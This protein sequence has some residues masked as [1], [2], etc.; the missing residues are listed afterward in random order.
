VIFSGPIFQVSDPLLFVVLVA[1]FLFGLVLHNVVQSRLAAYF[2][3]S[4]ARDSGTTSTEPQIHFDPFSLLWYLLVG[5]CTPRTIIVRGSRMRGRGADE[6]K[7]WLS[8]PL[9]LIVWAFILL[10][11]SKLVGILGQS[12][13][14]T[15]LTS[16]LFSAALA[17]ILHAVVF[18]FPL[19]GLDG[20]NALYAVG[21]YQTRQTLDRIAS[22]GPVLI[23]IFFIVL[24]R[25]GVF[26]SLVSPILNG[27]ETILNLIFVQP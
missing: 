26:G 15:S 13:V 6:V 24:S 18:I 5:F 20:G 2:G 9:A 27:M 25:T 19:P 7:V 3:D 8:G 23:F 16:G 11:L 22:A 14:I 1:S 21:N 10:L 17:S 12:N 4:S